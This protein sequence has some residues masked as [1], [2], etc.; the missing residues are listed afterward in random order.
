MV[1]RVLNLEN[2]PFNKLNPAVQKET[3]EEM[4]NNFYK[5]PRKTLILI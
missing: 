4:L 1:L 5:V 2:N 3:V